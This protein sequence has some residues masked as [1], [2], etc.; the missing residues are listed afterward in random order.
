MDS[1]EVN[2][3]VVKLLSAADKIHGRARE[4][5]REREE[6]LRLAGR[7]VSCCHY[8]PALDDFSTRCMR[9]LRRA[10]LVILF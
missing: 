9:W 5:E 2:E 10:R 1:R 3:I 6:I 7:V 8:T 4:R